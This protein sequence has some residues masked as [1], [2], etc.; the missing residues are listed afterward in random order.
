MILKVWQ[1]EVTS[2]L[3]LKWLKTSAPQKLQ[4]HLVSAYLT[5]I[6]INWNYNSFWFLKGHTPLEYSVSFVNTE[7]N[8]TI[9]R[10]C[11]F[12]IYW[13]VEQDESL[14]DIWSYFN[15]STPV[16]PVV[17]YRC[18]S[19]TLKKAEHQRIDAFKLCC[20]RRLLRVPWTA[21]SNQS[22]LKEIN[23]EYLLEGLMLR[24]KLQYFGHLMQRANKQ[25]CNIYFLSASGVKLDNYWWFQASCF[26]AFFGSHR[27]GIHTLP[28]GSSGN[29]A[30]PALLCC[31]FLLVS[32][33]HCHLAV[34]GI[35]PRCVGSTP[36]TKPGNLRDACTRQCRAHIDGSP[37]GQLLSPCT[38]FSTRGQVLPRLPRRS[39]CRGGVGG[40]LVPPGSCQVNPPGHVLKQGHLTSHIVWQSS[41][42]CV[43]FWTKCKLL[44][45]D[46]DTVYDAPFLPSCLVTFYLLDRQWIEHF[47]F[48]PHDNPLRWALSLFLQWRNGGL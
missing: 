34:V 22:I 38:G 6:S 9:D 48:N 20:W 47:P 44:S 42:P 33:L 13:I 2:L 3:W 35:R 26:M 17:M 4:A 8:K 14:V 15:C 31:P 16:F 11:I 40:G 1:W 41:S 27:V 30:L 24:L 37:A 19:W 7:V 46:I 32:Y 10:S 25:V 28:A 39:S 23:P 45:L 18:E 5:T 43:V 12:E 29:P 21:R 36:C